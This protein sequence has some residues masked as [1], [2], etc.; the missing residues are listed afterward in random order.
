MGSIIEGNLPAELKGLSEV[1]G[2]SIESGLKFCGS[3]R[4]FDKFLEAF[5]YDIDGK[6]AELLDA[7]QNGDI[8]Y[9]TIKA[10]ALKTS[11]RMIGAKQLSE[12]A[13][14]LEMAG[15]ANDKGYIKA[16]LD[17]FIK[18]YVSYKTRLFPYMS[19]KQQQK[20]NKRPISEE[21]LK[22][23][24]AALKEVCPSMDYDAV[25]MILEELD[26]YKLPTQTQK[27]VAEITKQLRR[28]DWDKIEILLAE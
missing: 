7:F 6:Q 5:Y 4:E 10:H 24:F 25:E 15:K 16:N 9:F 27:R 22:E 19:W 17:D 13:L 28:M 26:K 14:G 2:I 18:L 8:E 11:A 12:M 3:V 1:E 23:A 20:A 21:E